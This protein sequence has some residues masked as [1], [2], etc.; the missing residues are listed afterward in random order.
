MC[1]QTQIDWT[2]TIQNMSDLLGF[3]TKNV[4]LYTNNKSYNKNY[5]KK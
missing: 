4:L 1:N 3:G 2:L 5:K